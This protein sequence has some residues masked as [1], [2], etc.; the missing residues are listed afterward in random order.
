MSFIWIINSNGRKI[1]PRGTPVV[2][3]NVHKFVPSQFT[4]W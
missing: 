4:K 1:E 3:D 2:I